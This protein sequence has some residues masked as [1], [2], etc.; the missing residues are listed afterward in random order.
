VALRAAGP[1]SAPPGE[2][3]G[4]RDHIIVPTTSQ[5]QALADP[6]A[7]NNAEPPWRATARST[8]SAFT[9][10][11]AAVM[12]IV[13]VDHA[14]EAGSHPKPG[15]TVACGDSPF[16]PPTGLRS[17]SPSASGHQPECVKLLGGQSLSIDKLKVVR[18]WVEGRLP[19][20]VYA[21]T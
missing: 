5:A 12:G 13:H 3:G 6:L 7:E 21:Q 2:D 4:H 16:T 11:A 14:P 18:I 10:S 9:A 19:F 17:N 1:G 15:M 20:G 8:A